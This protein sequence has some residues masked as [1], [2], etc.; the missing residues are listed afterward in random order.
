MKMTGKILPHAHSAMPP[1]A[2]AKATEPQVPA[3]ACLTVVRP[4]PLGV[5]RNTAF[6]P[7][8]PSATVRSIMGAREAYVATLTIK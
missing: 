8:N 2:R 4:S 3:K 6:L 5:M 1:T 7:N